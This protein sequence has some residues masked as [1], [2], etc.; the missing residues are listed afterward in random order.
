ME[1]QHSYAVSR[2]STGAARRGARIQG[3]S[4]ISPSRGTILTVDDDPDALTLLRLLLRSE[5]FEV[6]AAL[7][8][9][10][11][12]QCVRQQMPDLIITDLTMPGMTG[13]ELC[14]QLR[15]SSET[16]HI[17][18]IVHTALSVP[19][20]DPLYD[21]AFSK[22]VDFSALLSRVHRLLAVARSEEV[23][24]GESS[25]RASSDSDP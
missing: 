14:K 5:G 19:P 18:I 9:P 21:R 22:P 10:A 6:Q 13:L 17:P 3:S 11:A 2:P 7:S 16:R 8:G 24:S 25:R 4:S 23:R 12:L 15:D 20:T 1:S